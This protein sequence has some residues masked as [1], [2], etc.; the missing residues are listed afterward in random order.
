MSGLSVNLQD[1]FLNQV[2]KEGIQVEVMLLNGAVF[3]GHIKGFDNFTLIM[4]IDGKQHLIYKHAISQMIAPR[5]A[6]R[7]RP[8]HDGVE[9]AEQ[10]EETPHAHPARRKENKTDHKSEP[11]QPEKFNAIDLSG[12]KIGSSKDEQ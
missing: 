5:F 7:V 6:A 1:G 4:H 2:R 12:I 10:G 11:R 9:P 8:E 3:Q